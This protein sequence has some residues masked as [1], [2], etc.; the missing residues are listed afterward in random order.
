M[1]KLRM[2]RLVRTAGKA[3][4]CSTVSENDHVAQ[5]VLDAVHNAEHASDSIPSHHRAPCPN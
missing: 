2:A 4:R 1:A 3:I 5:L